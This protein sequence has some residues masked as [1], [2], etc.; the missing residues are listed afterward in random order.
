MCGVLLQNV[1]GSHFFLDTLVS[2][3]LE[4]LERRRLIHDLTFLRKFGRVPQRL[5]AAFFD[6]AR[7][8]KRANRT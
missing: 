8:Q 6:V 3:N 7:F 4:T 1:Y 5:L 2:L